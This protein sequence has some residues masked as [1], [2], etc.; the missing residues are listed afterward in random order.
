MK[1]QIVEDWLNS[2]EK[3]V[4]E[5]N[6]DSI[7]SLFAD[8][9]YWRDLISFTWNI[10]TFESKNDISLMLNNTLSEINPKNFSLIDMKTKT[11]SEETWFS[12]ETKYAKCKGHIRLKE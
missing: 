4:E 12:F 11:S 5:R 7:L 1:T 2:F 9:T 3:H 10:I 6:I 8:T